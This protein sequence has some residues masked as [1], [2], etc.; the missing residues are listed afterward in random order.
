LNQDGVF[1]FNE[2]M[3]ILFIYPQ[4]SN[5]II[6]ALINCPECN[7]EI[8]D[9]AES[10]SNCGF[11]LKKEEKPQPTKTKTSSNKSKNIGYIVFSSALPTLMM[12]SPRC[13]KVM[14]MHRSFRIT[15]LKLPCQPD[16]A[17]SAKDDSFQQRCSSGSV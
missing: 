16:R 2:I 12:Q 7:K 8:S 15:L 5:H 3:V 17:D 11:K 9:K 6:I 14:H 13:N 4:T 10:C 1:D